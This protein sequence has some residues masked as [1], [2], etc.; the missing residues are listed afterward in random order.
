MARD[1]AAALRVREV[2]RSV[3]LRQ[4]SLTHYFPS[5]P[6]LLD[7][8]FADGFTEL[9]ER[10]DRLPI[11]LDPVDAVVSV[12]VAV[13]DYC[14]DHPTR[15]HL[16][17]QR[18][19]PGFAPSDKLALG[20]LS[21]LV[22]RLA[23]ADVTAPADVALIR[24]QI[25]GLAAAARSVGLLP[26]RSP[27]T[28]TDASSPIVPSA[29]SAHCCL[30]P[31][32]PPNPN[33][34]DPARDRDGADFAFPLGTLGWPVRHDAGMV[35]HAAKSVPPWRHTASSAM[36]WTMPSCLAPRKPIVHPRPVVRCR[37]RIENRT[38][39]RWRTSPWC[40]VLRERWTQARGSV[41]DLPDVTV[42]IAEARG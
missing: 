2:A 40:A 23:A 7:A 35:R 30:L 11:D 16:M 14:V 19:V 31:N 5:K 32:R 1:G 21:V 39:Q 3:G 33:G 29:A 20:C 27:T 28:R 12:A 6:D 18:S 10:L 25:S 37:V 24:G 41:R 38:S 36:T 34:A 9:R 17:L 15:Y 13:V 8:L 4:Q 26:S 42:R 22:D